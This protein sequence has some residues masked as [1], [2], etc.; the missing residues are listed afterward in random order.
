MTEDPVGSVGAVCV[1]ECMK[2]NCL[3]LTVLVL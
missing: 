3:Q 2:C 1:Y